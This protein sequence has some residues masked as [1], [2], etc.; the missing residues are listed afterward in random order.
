MQGLGS[1]RGGRLTHVPEVHPRPY[2]LPSYTSLGGAT[3][4]LSLGGEGR[5]LQSETEERAPPMPA[6][7]ERSGER[8]LPNPPSVRRL[9]PPRRPA[10]RAARPAVRAAGAPASR[11]TKG[12]FIKRIVGGSS[13]GGGGREKR[14]YKDKKRWSGGRSCAASGSP[15]RRRRPGSPSGSEADTTRP[16]GTREAARACGGLGCPAAMLPS[17]LPQPGNGIARPRGPG[18]RDPRG[19]LPRE[20]RALF[21]AN[22][23][24]IAQARGDFASLFQ[25]DRLSYARLARPHNVLELAL[26][27]PLGRTQLQ[28]RGGAKPPA[29]IFGGAPGGFPP[30]LAG[31]GRRAVLPLR[32]L[33]PRGAGAPGA[34][35]RSPVGAASSRQLCSG[36]LSRGEFGRGGSERRRA[37]R[38]HTPHSRS[39]AANWVR[40]GLGEILRPAPTADWP[41]LWEPVCEGSVADGIRAASGPGCVGSE[42]EPTVSPARPGEPSWPAP[43]CLLSSVLDCP[44]PI[45]DARRAPGCRHRPQSRAMRAALSSAQPV[46]E[47]GDHA[48]RQVGRVLGANFGVPRLSVSPG[49]RFSATGTTSAGHKC[50]PAPPDQSDLP[51]PPS[52]LPCCGAPAA[53]AAAAAAGAVP[54]GR[55]ATGAGSLASGARRAARPDC[56]SPLASGRCPRARPRPAASARS[57]VHAGGAAAAASICSLHSHRPAPRRAPGRHR[58][59]AAA[60]PPPPRPG[61]VLTFR[62]RLRAEERRSHGRRVCPLAP[63]QT[64]KATRCDGSGDQGSQVATAEL[65]PP[66]SWPSGPPPPTGPPT[67]PPAGPPPP[68][69]RALPRPRPGADPVC[70]ARRGARARQPVS[71]LPGLRPAEPPRELGR[72]G[73]SQRGV[74]PGQTPAASAGTRVPRE[75]PGDEPE[76][77]VLP[78]PGRRGRWLLSPSPRGLAR[79]SPPGSPTGPRFLTC[80]SRA[81]AGSELSS[82]TPRPARQQQRRAQP[83]SGLRAPACTSQ[84]RPV[85]S[86]SGHTR[87]SCGPGIKGGASAAQR[88]RRGSAAQPGYWEGI[89]LGRA[90]PG[91]PWRR[92]AA[93]RGY[94]SLVTELMAALTFTPDKAAMESRSPGLL[95]YCEE[96][97]GHPGAMAR[98]MPTPPVGPGSL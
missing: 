59:R 72:P 17:G 92:P 51:R 20:T 13:G 62:G 5:G 61:R 30:A 66:R 95:G 22:S 45:P 90:Q 19:G 8:R 6:P 63:A 16:V 26:G 88:A 14:I 1:V 12:L 33:G 69:P 34:P 78:L 98:V 75:L 79:A 64:A 4:A 52:A 39:V 21:P 57:Q 91:L 82:R 85:T 80:T 65:H 27:V 38:A 10:S 81:A 9:W 76:R 31:A 83:Q 86:T 43:L 42:R 18:R 7:G 71:R 32:G 67:G 35:G 40:V 70:A 50:S 87:P 49:P 41:E 25:R 37:R 46:R 84:E 15:E 68:P 93:R 47:G 73:L 54:E 2:R 94:C 48:Q 28:K 36:L 89:H 96:G 23:F 44:C 55:A 74:I 53:A 3:A 24:E 60:G 11:E 56:R 29:R 58:P 97:G 77:A